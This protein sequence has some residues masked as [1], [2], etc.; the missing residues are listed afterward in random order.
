MIS[1]SQLAFLIA[2]YLYNIVTPI[3]VAMPLNLPRSDLVHRPGD[4]ASL[5]EGLVGEALE[6]PQ[7]HRGT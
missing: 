7:R 5:R 6:L 4:G 1:V 3:S 2:C